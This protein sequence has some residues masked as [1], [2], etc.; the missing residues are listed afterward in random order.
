MTITE[1]N[2][3]PIDNVLVQKISAECFEWWKRYNKLTNASKDNALHFTESV[4]SEILGY[5]DSNGVYH[6]GTFDAVYNKY[7]YEFTYNMLGAF[8][9]ELKARDQ[10]AYPEDIDIVFGGGK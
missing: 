3:K 5:T 1:K 10:G 4:W 7:P 8:L 9:D 6:V 2:L